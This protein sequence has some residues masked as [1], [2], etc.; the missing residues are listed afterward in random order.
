MITAIILVKYTIGCMQYMYYMYD[1]DR[2]KIHY[3]VYK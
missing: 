2:V 1:I 3:H